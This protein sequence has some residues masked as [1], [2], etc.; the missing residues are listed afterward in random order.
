MDWVNGLIGRLGVVETHLAA[1][2]LATVL[3]LTGAAFVMFYP[4]LRSVGSKGRGTEKSDP[5][6]SA[7][8]KSKF[9]SEQPGGGARD[10]FGPPPEHAPA[11][12]A[13]SANVAPT[14]DYR[15]IVEHIEQ[16]VFKVDEGG[17]LVFL[18]PSWEHLLDF[19][20]ADSLDE[21]FTNFIH[22]EDR[23]AADAQ[24]SSVLRGRRERCQLETRMI[25]RNGTAHWLELRA[26]GVQEGSGHIIGTLTDISERKQVESGL[27]A[28]R[29]SLSTLLNS[30]PGMVYRCKANRNWSFEF[31]SDGC[32]D[33]TGY[34]PFQLVNDP[35]F[36]FRQIM[37]PDD[38]DFAWNHVHHQV[39]L[40]R[41]F[42]LVYRIINRTGQVKWVWEQGRGVYSSGGDLLA[43][44][45]FITVVANDAP[46]AKP[47]LEQFQELIY[48]EQVTLKRSGN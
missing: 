40:H 43:L 2:I 46:H 6:H 45:G 19:S 31:A 3:L 21:P 36:Y 30:I 11:H 9:S 13:R 14:P 4:L 33:V 8:T 29:R 48:E 16:I 47:V 42:Q 39:M 27:R 20:I 38:R 5:P 10:G 23:T 25:G 17:L 15:Q 34:E 12:Q 28:V 22:P 35:D 26:T 41:D 44:E 7:L 32:S 24:L 1:F 37:F 18:S